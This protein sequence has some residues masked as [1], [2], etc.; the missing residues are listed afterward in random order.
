M[1]LDVEVT[2]AK[3]V[4]KPDKSLPLGEHERVTVRI[5]TQIGRIA[6]SAGL[7]P[8]PDQPEAVDYLLGPGNQFWEQQP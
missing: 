1:T 4:L 3:G 8:L 5:Q 6:Q 2:Y 7:I